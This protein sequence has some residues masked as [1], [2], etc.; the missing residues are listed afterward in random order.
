MLDSNKRNI[1]LDDETDYSKKPCMTI[2]Q[3]EKLIG[4]HGIYNTQ[5]KQILKLTTDSSYTKN[6]Y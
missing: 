5:R 1:I 3:D 4:V 2:A 6:I